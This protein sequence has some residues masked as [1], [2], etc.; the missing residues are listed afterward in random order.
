[1]ND[2]IDRLDNLSETGQTLESY[3][4]LGAGTVVTRTQN[5]RGTSLTYVKLSGESDGDAG[6]KYTGLD[7]FGRIS[8]QRWVNSSGTAVDWYQY[9]YDRDS[10]VTS[11]ENLVAWHA[12]LVHSDF[13]EAYTYDGLNRLTAT[14]RYNGTAADQAFTLDGNGNITSLS[15]NGTAVSRTSNDFNQLTGVGGATLAY[16]ANGSMTTDDQGHTLTYD[17]WNRLVS[18][19]NGGTTLATYAYDGAG[20]RVKATASGATTDSYFSGSVVTEDYR[21]GQVYERTIAAP[22]Y[23]NA[24]LLR[25]K[26]TDANGTLDQRVYLT[27]D[28]NHNVTGV[29]S[30]SG[31]VL[32]HQVY[33]A[34]GEVTFTDASWTTGSDAYGLSRLFQGMLY[35]AAS[36]WYVTPNRLYRA[37]LAYWNRVDPAQADGLNWYVP[38]ADN[39]INGEDPTGLWKIDRS[40]GERAE[41]TP[42]PRDSLKTLARQIGL[43][44]SEVR[45][46]LIY[47]DLSHGPSELPPNYLPGVDDKVGNNP[48]CASYSVPNTAYV[49]LVDPGKNLLRL[50]IGATAQP[51]IEAWWAEGLKVRIHQFT[52]IKAGDVLAHLLDK[53][54]YRYFFGGHG[55]GGSIFV[56]NDAITSAS[57]EVR[58]FGIQEMVLYACETD[59]DRASW[60]IA[61]ARD[62]SL[63][64]YKGDVTPFTQTPVYGP[65][66]R[67]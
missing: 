40:G 24:V 19:K 11:K 50:R 14:D 12:P 21:G 43:N 18:V 29:I 20:R 34:Y 36:G 38:F 28:A 53:N 26:D 56:G 2:V 9:T 6:D 41:A 47:T 32:Q 45:K 51:Y 10:N 67:N 62:G 3:G 4:Y 30:T 65:G 33:S 25:D 23:V 48:G 5:Q 7:R 61:V 64:T 66:E 1:L 13:Y 44:I 46:W 27:A 42:E 49:D 31:T 8:Q 17:A 57:V 37:P 39:P 54:L 55:S 58:S 52:P 59:D 15:T 63:T 16:D 35:D 22:G 60:A